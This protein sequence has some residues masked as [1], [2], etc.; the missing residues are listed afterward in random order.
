MGSISYSVL[1]EAEFLFEKDILKNPR[2]SNFPPELKLF[3]QTVHFGQ[4][5]TKY[6]DQLATC[7]EYHRP[8]IF[9]VTFA[10]LLL[11][12]KHKVSPV[13]MIIKT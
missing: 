8:K 5:K 10:N 12:R 3:I 4:S 6:P 13:D 9:K 2:P 7:S 1:H 11:I